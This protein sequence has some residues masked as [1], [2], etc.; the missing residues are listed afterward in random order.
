[1]A[2][3]QPLDKKMLMFLQVFTQKNQ[4]FWNESQQIKNNLKI[5]T[6][7]LYLGLPNKKEMITD[8]LKSKNINICCLQETEVPM[9]YPENI[10]PMN[11][12]E[13][14]LNY[15]DY[16]LELELNDEKKRAGIYVSK[17]IK[18][19]RRYDLEKLNCHVLKP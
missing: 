6:W 2:L 10:V 13:N 1:M 18:Y 16:L 7:N 8:Y 12:P 17:N 4:T 19:K 9:N 15:G 3:E 14:I 11:Y 5:A